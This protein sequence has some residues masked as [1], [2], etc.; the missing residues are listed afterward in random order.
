MAFPEGIIYGFPV[1]TRYGEYKMIKDLEIDAFSR[2]RPGLHAE[3]APP[4]S[5]DGVKD[6]LK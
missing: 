3:G 1:V 6:P 4:K 5:R 2:E